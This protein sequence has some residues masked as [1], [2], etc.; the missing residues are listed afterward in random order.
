MNVRKPSGGA[1]ASEG[2]GG[3]GPSSCLSDSVRCNA[4]NGEWWRKCVCGDV[5]VCDVASG[6]LLRKCVR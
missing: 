4:V 1:D 3:T 5:S 2:A 6:G